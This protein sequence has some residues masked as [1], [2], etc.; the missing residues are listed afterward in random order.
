MVNPRIM[1]LE[2]MFW[3][4]IHIVRQSLLKMPCKALSWAKSIDDP[5][6]TERLCHVLNFLLSQAVHRAGCCRR[7]F[8][9]VSLKGAKAMD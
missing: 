6:L 1:G 9:A 8:G 4:K 2:M 7:L 3:G 5:G